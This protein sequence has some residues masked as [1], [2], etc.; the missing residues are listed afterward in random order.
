MIGCKIRNTHTQEQIR[1]WLAVTPID[2]YRVD[3]AQV[4]VED[5]TGERS[6][7]IL[8]RGRWDRNRL[9]GRSLAGVPVCREAVFRNGE[10]VVSGRGI[11]RNRGR[12]A[13]ANADV[14]SALGGHPVYERL[15]RRKRSDRVQKRPGRR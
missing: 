15:S 4:R 1:G 13:D 10:Q 11:E 9:N 6:R 7:A 3:L 2:S 14:I 12:W 5:R 8:G